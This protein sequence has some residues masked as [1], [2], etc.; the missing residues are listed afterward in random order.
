M[1]NDLYVTNN[2]PLLYYKGKQYNASVRKSA[3]EKFD[4]T[5]S[6]L[7]KMAIAAVV[8]ELPSGK[9]IKGKY[10]TKGGYNPNE[11]KS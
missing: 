11:E 4:G 7:E 10:S 5:K 3:I 2:F 1:L 9:I 8:I 6:F